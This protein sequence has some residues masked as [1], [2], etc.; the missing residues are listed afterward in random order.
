MGLGDPNKAKQ[1]LSKCLYYMKIGS[2]DYYNNYLLKILPISSNDQFAEYLVSRY[3]Q[4]MKSYVTYGRNGGCAENLTD[5]AY[6]FDE[7]LKSQLERFNTNNLSAD[8]KFMFVN[9][10]GEIPGFT[11]ANT[12]CCPTLLNMSCIQNG[13]PCGNRTEYLYWDGFHQ[14][15]SANRITAQRAN[16]T[17]FQS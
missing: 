15:E 11:F 10:T 6:T 13:T 5:D 14:T 12:S 7:K 2:N 1:Y 17:L 4:S 3:S 16:D 8:A 9:A